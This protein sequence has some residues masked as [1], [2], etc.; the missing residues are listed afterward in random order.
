MVEQAKYV[1]EIEPRFEVDNI[2]AER[3]HNSLVKYIYIGSTK[4][5]WPELG[6]CV[7]RKPQ[8]MSHP[9]QHFIIFSKYEASS[10]GQNENNYYS[11]EH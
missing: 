5:K 3:V 7:I 1:Y 2:C 6:N 8:K 11:E 9:H 10:T 4:K